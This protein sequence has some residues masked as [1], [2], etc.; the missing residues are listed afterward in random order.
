M[1]QIPLSTEQVEV[2]AVLGLL[3]PVQVQA[4][5]LLADDPVLA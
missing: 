5:T 3:V 4:L 1:E 2:E